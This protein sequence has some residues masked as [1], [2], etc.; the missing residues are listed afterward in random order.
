[1]KLEELIAKISQIEEHAALMLA[2]P[3]RLSMERQR[4]ILGLARQIR[5]HL[6]DQLRAGARHP[7]ENDKSYRSTLQEQQSR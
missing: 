5:A 6:Q 2:E 7:A 1:M 3:R 4:F